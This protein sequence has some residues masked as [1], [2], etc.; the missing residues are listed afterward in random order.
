MLVVLQPLDP[1]MC[2][3]STLYSFVLLVPYVVLAV[4]ISF[5]AS[6]F[7]TMNDRFLFYFS[8]SIAN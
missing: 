4:S 2:L 1:T 3:A 8:R 7:S 5:Y 6:K